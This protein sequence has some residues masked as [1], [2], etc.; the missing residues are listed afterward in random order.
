MGLRWSVKDGAKIILM[1]SA[2]V[3][4]LARLLGN[5]WLVWFRP[6]DLAWLEVAKLPENAEQEI[7]TFIDFKIEP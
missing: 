1:S 5:A 7:L 2:I 3:K 6:C 4:A